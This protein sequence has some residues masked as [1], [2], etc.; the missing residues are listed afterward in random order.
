MKQPILSGL[1]LLLLVSSSYAQKKKTPNPKPET[2]KVEVKMQPPPP[3][4][5]TSVEGITE[6]RLANGLRVLLFPDQS[7]QT[8]TVNVTYGGFQTRELW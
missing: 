8:F 7:K 4:K 3:V 5:V 2:P 1:I 6:Y